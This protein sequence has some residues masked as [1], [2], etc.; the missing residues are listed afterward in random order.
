MYTCLR[1]HRVF[2]CEV[3][4]GDDASDQIFIHCII[5]TGES[6][7]TCVFSSFV[8][9]TSWVGLRSWTACWM[10]AG[11]CC[12]LLTGG[13]TFY[14]YLKWLLICRIETTSSTKSPAKEIF[15]CKPSKTCWFSVKGTCMEA[16]KSQNNLD[17]IPNLE[18]QPLLHVC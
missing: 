14:F 4:N 5:N 13:E 3:C 9:S 18:I 12:S 10:S 2:F 7:Q 8:N 6:H 17:F 1:W 16:K 11:P 15:G